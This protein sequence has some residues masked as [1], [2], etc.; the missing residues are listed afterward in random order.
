[1]SETNI[2]D[3]ITNALTNVIKKGRFFEK[4]EKYKKIIFCFIFFTTVVNTFLLTTNM[5][6][7][8]ILVRIKKYIKNL[9]CIENLNNE[10][11]LLREEIIC[12]RRQ[13]NNNFDNI[14]IK[15]T[16]KSIKEASTFI[17]EIVDDLIDDLINKSNDNLDEEYRNDLIDECYDNIPCNNVKK[18]TVFN[19]LFNW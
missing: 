10:N 12:L 5:Y 13:I 14:E 8:Y 2:T 15:N 7:S 3:S 9:K 17:T 1:M 11:T 19:R 6:N 18:Y 4:K 16:N